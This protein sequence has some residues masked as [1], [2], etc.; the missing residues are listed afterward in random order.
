MQ[1]LQTQS[2]DIPLHDIKTIIEV[3]EYS[4]YYLLAIVAISS[5][6]VLG[7]IYLIYKYFKNRNI[8]NERKEHFKILT[9]VDLKDTKKAAYAITFYGATFKDDG[10]RQKGMYQ[11]LIDRL[12][13]YKYKKNVD[14]FDG[15][16]LSYIELYK[17]MIDV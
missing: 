4:F 11:N 1:N 15:E 9:S 14:D 6:V 10:D 13:V 17:G 2:Y 16:T 7:F 5:I 8:Y 3:Q 12:E